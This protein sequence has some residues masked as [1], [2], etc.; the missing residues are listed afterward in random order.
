VLK[1]SGLPRDEII[2]GWRKMHNEELP[3][4]YSLTNIIRMIMTKRKRSV[5]YVARMGEE[6][7]I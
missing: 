7:C 1:T 6:G 4:L 2:G 3:N 5:G